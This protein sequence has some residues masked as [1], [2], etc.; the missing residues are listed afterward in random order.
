MLFFFSFSL[1]FSS[2]HQCKHSQQG[3]NERWAGM[4]S[5]NFITSWCQHQPW[6]PSQS[7]KTRLEEVLMG[8]RCRREEKLGRGMLKPGIC[9]LRDQP[10]SS[11]FLVFSREMCGLELSKVHWVSSL[12][13]LL[14]LIL[15]KCLWIQTVQ[16]MMNCSLHQW[17]WDTWHSDENWR[18]NFIYKSYSD[19]DL[20]GFVWKR[21]CW[22]SNIH[23]INIY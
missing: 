14:T 10:W 17:S 19:T 18:E 23:S 8:R 9:S 7:R 6:Q 2:L 12:E 21:T 1:F 5:Y 15:N 13:G 4:R 3:G 16:F 22:S 20:F 11:E